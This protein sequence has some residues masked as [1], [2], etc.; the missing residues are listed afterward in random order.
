MG[1]SAS[2]ICVQMGG[3][4]EVEDERFRLLGGFPVAVPAEYRHVNCLAAFRK[5]SGESLCFHPDFNDQSCCRATAV[6]IP[7]L[8]FWA[9]VFQVV[10][11]VTMEDCL[12][13]LCL[14]N[15]VLV[16]AQGLSLAYEQGRSLLPIGRRVFSF[17]QEEAL[18]FASG[19]G[20]SQRSLPFLCRYS[21]K[22]DEA[23]LIASDDRHHFLSDC[24]LVFQTQAD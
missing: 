6:L 15:A 17:D 1:I 22:G 5:A 18:P 3:K 24:L 10:K 8:R 9:E 16:G 7:G 11:R 23:G 4:V 2:G 12:D 21:A 19:F 14:Q 13:F 20:W